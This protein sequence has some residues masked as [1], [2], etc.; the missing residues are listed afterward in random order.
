MSEQQGEYPCIN[1]FHRSHVGKEC[2]YCPM[3][4]KDN[5]NSRCTTYTR[6][7]LFTARTIARIE[8]VLQQA[9]GQTMMALSTI[10][11]LLAEANPEAA[12]SLKEK[13]EARQKA[14]EAQMAA[15]QAQRQAEADEA[16]TAAN[17]AEEERKMEELVETYTAQDNVVQ[18]PTKE[19]E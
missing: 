2:P 5:P 9:H 14:A 11:D 12:D 13:L 7:D 6:A 1:C 4:T 18:F 19:S 3:P 17:A 16:L 15:E 10:F 8:Q